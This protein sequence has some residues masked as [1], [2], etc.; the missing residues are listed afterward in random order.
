M[1]LCWVP[2][3]RSRFVVVVW[4]GPFFSRIL[5]FYSVSWNPVFAQLLCGCSQLC[6]DSSWP[7]HNI[8]LSKN[9]LEVATRLST[10]D[11][12][13]LWL[14]IRFFDVPRPIF[15]KTNVFRKD[16]RRCWL[17]FRKGRLTGKDV[18]I[19]FRCGHFKN[20]PFRWRKLIFT[21]NA[22]SLSYSKCKICKR[23]VSGLDPETRIWCRC[24]Q[25]DV[26]GLIR[27]RGA[28]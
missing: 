4:F 1:L 14:F 7:S 28:R 20:R 26:V 19:I 22:F 12:L 16:P 8:P 15:C 18:P 5:G 23:S 2:A 10:S 24:L 9:I 6:R 3:E 13:S 17:F 11:A 25:D 27:P 21:K